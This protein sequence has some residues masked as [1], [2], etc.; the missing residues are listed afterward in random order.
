M[1]MKYSTIFKSSLFALALAVSGTT[2]TA[3]EDDVVIPNGNPGIL[4][5]VDGTYGFVKSMAGARQLTTLPVFG[6]ESA[7]GHLY[8]ELSQAASSDLQVTFQIDEAALQAYNQKNGTSYQ[9]YPAAQLSLSNGGKATVKAGSRQ[10]GSVTLNIAQGG[11]IGQTYA[12]AVSA[13][14]T[15]GVTLS[16][17]NQSYIYLVKP[18]PA[19]PDSKKGDIMTHCFVEVNNENILNMGEYTMKQSGKPFFDVVSIFAANINVDSESGRVHIFC[20]DQVTYLLENADKYIRPLQAKG[21]KVNLSIL[22]NHDEAGM[23]SLSAEAARDFA[24]EIK[25]YMDVY[26]LDGVDFDDEYTAYSSEPNP[27]FLPRSR[28]NYARL[29]YEC[30]QVMPDKL[31]GVYYYRGIDSPAGSVEGKS[32]GELVDYITYGYYQNQSNPAFGNEALFEGLPK[33]KYCPMPWKINE[34]LA[35]GW[36]RF[37]QDNFESL[38]EQGYGLQMFYNPKPMLYNYQGL[39]S[40]IADIYYDDTVEWSGKYYNRTGT[41]YNGQP[42]TYDYFIGEWEATSSNSLYVYIDENDNPRWWDWGGSHTTTI[43]IEPKEE[44]KSYY[45]YNWGT[46][47][48][49]TS[50][51]PLVMTYDDLSCMT[52]IMPQTIH[53]ADADDPDTWVMHWGTYGRTG[54]WRCYPHYT[55][56]GISGMINPDGTVTLMGVGNRWALDPYR[57][58]D[59]IWQVP[60]MDVKYHLT[61]NYTLRKK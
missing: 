18:Q 45:V 29:V 34:E 13:K 52:A 8:F 42:S 12:V 31:I 3:C 35:G 26:G 28:E 57:E 59:G 44:G 20:N 16:A 21:V 4:E 24:R 38:K 27:G 50:Q 46:Y 9:M 39:F 19:I 47:P 22:G 1:Y 51:Y 56:Y 23:G 2:F 58:V 43:R 41:A 30:R 32:V 14:A 49:I 17:N 5:T 54:E 48:E 10:S 37:N 7:T 36:T 11:T 40:T 33:S 53:E 6:T 25:A 60:H 15:D 55:D 61:E